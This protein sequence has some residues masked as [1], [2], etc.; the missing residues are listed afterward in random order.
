MLFPFQKMSILKKVKK[1]R[2]LKTPMTNMNLLKCQME[3]Y[4]YRV[5]KCKIN[6]INNILNFYN[7]VSETNYILYI[8]NKVYE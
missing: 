6:N 2:M 3:N 8:T 1:K 5:E 7:L 4:Y